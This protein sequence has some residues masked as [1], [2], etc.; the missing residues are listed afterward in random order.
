MADEGSSPPGRSKPLPQCK[1]LLICEDVFEDE[2]SGQYILH[3][4]IDVLRFSAFPG[5]SEPFAIFFQLY[6]G[7]G[8]YEVG[9]QF[10]DVSRGESTSSMVISQLDFTERFAKI[11]V[12]LPVDSLRLPR[13][14]QYELLLLLD[15]RELATQTLNAE[16]EDGQE[17][18]E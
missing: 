16:L 1:A 4:L 12:A 6:D 11:D 9:I 5:D 18:D 17:E 3:K 15:G 13:P 2:V 10:Y 14:G 8:R 7:I